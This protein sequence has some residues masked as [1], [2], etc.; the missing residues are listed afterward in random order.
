MYRDRDIGYLTTVA[1]KIVTDDYQLVKKILWWG[2]IHTVEILKSLPNN[3][4]ELSTGPGLLA[5]TIL[6]FG[7]Q[8]RAEAHKDYDYILETD[9]CKKYESYLHEGIDK[10]HYAYCA[11]KT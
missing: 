5:S 2:I 7:A 10:K 3:Y 8:E 6:S 1:A 4:L 11:A 9:V